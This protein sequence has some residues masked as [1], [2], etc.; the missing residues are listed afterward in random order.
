MTNALSSGAPDLPPLFK[1]SFAPVGE[2][3]LFLSASVVVGCSAPRGV[4]V[5]L[6][7]HAALL[8][9]EHAKAMR[10]ESQLSPPYF[11]G[12]LKT[13]ELANSWKSPGGPYGGGDP[14]D[15]SGADPVDNYVTS[16]IVMRRIMRLRTG[17]QQ[18]FAKKFLEK[19]PGMEVPKL[20]YHVPGLGTRLA[21]AVVSLEDPS[22]E[23]LVIL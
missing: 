19:F 11:R 8:M 9:S 22:Q 5:L 4:D 13:M 14:V 12:F 7:G 2:D 18:K 17:I 6:L 10:G 21:C 23:P 20:F 15:D 1:I 16:V 3:A